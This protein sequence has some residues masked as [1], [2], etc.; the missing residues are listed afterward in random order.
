MSRLQIVDVLMIDRHSVCL[1]C[2]DIT[3]LSVPG[4]SPAG[5]AQRHLGPV[6]LARPVP[7]P[8]RRGARRHLAA[9]ARLRGAGLV[10]GLVRGEVRLVDEEEAGRVRHHLAL[11]LLPAERVRDGP[12]DLLPGH[13]NLY[14]STRLQPF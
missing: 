8:R 10:Q 2:V 5:D 13:I 4:G 6:P 11:P 14:K 3:F 9:A 12:G 7:G 1:S